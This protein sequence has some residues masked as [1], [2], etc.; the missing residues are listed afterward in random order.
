M[1]N[2]EPA[3]D[4]PYIPAKATTGAADLLRGLIGKRLM[5]ITG[6][7]NTILSVCV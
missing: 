7:V 5:T 4:G 6:S 3:A 2:A 1:T